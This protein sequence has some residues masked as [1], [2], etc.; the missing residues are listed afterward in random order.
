MEREDINIM[1]YFF[2]I[3][4]ARKFIIWNFIIVTVLA[5]GVSL[6]L[7]KYYKSKTILLPPTETQ[8]A[9]GFSDVLSAMPITRLTLGAKGS[10]TDVTLG[11]LKSETMAI[12]LID[13]FNL[14]KVYKTK[15]RD[16]SSIILKR[17]SKV[18]LTKEGLI[19]VEVQDRDPLRSAAIANMHVTMLDSI[20]QV[21][22]QRMAKERADFIEQQIHENDIS[23]KQSETALKEFQLKN[24][25][26]SPLQQQQV[27]ITVSAELEM[28]L[29]KL[30]SQL[31]EYNAKS[32]SNIHPLVR[33]VKNKITIYEELL[34]KMRFGSSLDDRE[35]LFVPLQESPDLTLHYARLARRVEILGMLEQLLRQHY[36]ES[37]IQQVNT[38]ST[39]SVLDR[40]RPPQ[41]KHRPKRKLIVLVA[42][43]GSIFFSIVSILIIEFFNRLAEFS[44]DNRRK[45]QQFARFMRIND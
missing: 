19:E 22:N 8:K 44:E 28:E 24:K 33:E 40:A 41:Q 20:K 39:I 18:S 4:K 6:I 43:A 7:P 32:F 26:I 25:A 29:I 14:N 15:N 42:G 34:H 11:I 16:Q 10:P 37:R 35:S 36:E 17:M 27:A 3:F 38:T 31:K 45:M 1:N 30:E 9:F 5:A 12:A 23:L 21:I 2:L 13:K